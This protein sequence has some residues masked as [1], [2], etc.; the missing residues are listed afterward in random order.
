[1]TANVSITTDEKENVISVP[2]GLLVRRDGKTYVRILA[3][4][5]VQEREVRLGGSSSLGE[6]EILNG[7]S[8]GDIIVTTLP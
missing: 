4:G 7:L 2:Q 1:M 6:V 5:M 8:Q 3:A